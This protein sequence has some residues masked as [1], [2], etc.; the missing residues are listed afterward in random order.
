MILTFLS[1]T[2][3][4]CSLNQDASCILKRFEMAYRV[5]IL[6]QGEEH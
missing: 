2:E 5:A 3:I 6:L 1:C 4:V